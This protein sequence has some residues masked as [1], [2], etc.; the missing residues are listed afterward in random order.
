[1]ALMNLPA[2][3]IL[4]S[5]IS[6]SSLKLGHK[7]RGRER[8]GGRARTTPLFTALLVLLAGP[9]VAKDLWPAFPKSARIL[10]Q[11]DSIT[12]GNRGRTADPNHILGHGY[13]FIIA[14]EFAG[15]FP[16][17]NLTFANRGVSGNTVADLAARW[18]RDTLDVHPDVLSVLIGVNDVAKG[19][20]A[21]NR[22]S[23]E[24][25]ES[26]Y[27]RILAQARAANP[28]L[29]LMLCEPF[30]LPGRA[31]QAHYED[32]EADIR[33]LQQVVEKLAAKYQAPVVHFQ[34]LFDDATNR[35]PVSYWIWDGVHPTYAG[36]QLMA[37]EWV[38]VYGSFYGSPLLDPQ[39]N[40]AV[41]PLPKL[42]QDSYDWYQRHAAVL[43][44]QTNMEPEIVLVGDS[45][46]HFWAGEP[47]ANHQNGSNSWAQT[48]GGHAV[49][50]LGFGWDRTQN[51]LWRLD[52][53]EM[54]GLTPR[55]IV[56]NI[57]CNNF[58]GT[59]NARANTPEEVCAAIQIIC[60]RLLAKSPASR[61]VVMGVFPR[62]ASATDPKRA[63]HRKLNELLSAA[64]AGRPQVTFLD[65]GDKFLEPDGS[66][67]REIFS[68]GTHPT[69][70]G[71][72]IWGQALSDA[73]IFGA[74]S[75]E[76]AK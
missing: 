2:I 10:F 37:D 24:R 61:M 36:H 69:D 4:T 49:L 28:Q 56:L 18:Q 70:K 1:M 33:K 23:A 50:N 45:I 65:I 19:I 34:K 12:D 57:G 26:D 53:G 3:L 40:S 5:G 63:L 32:W 42:E 71:Y 48:F 6:S 16:E 75:T 41:A 20:G 67:S 11:G 47:R 43:N 17:L 60:D 7:D 52:H 73:G 64:L 38:R 66:L 15:Q 31:N 35:A 68:D 27:D 39:R 22:V 29:K 76:A 14:S 30:I 72:A 13:Q 51:V 54:D 62:G 9:S 58:S 8:G 44:L 21:T 59:A 74:K 25:F 46:T 55:T